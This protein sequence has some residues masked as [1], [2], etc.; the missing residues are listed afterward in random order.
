[1]ISPL[2]NELRFQLLAPLI[3]E[4][5]QIENLCQYQLWNKYDF[6]KHQMYVDEVFFGY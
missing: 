6:K 4:G 2:Q 1:M 3:W 5:G